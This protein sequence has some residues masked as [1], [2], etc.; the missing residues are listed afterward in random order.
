[1]DRYL[2]E[3]EDYL[4]REKSM[5]R[6]SMVA[7][8]RDLVEFYNFLVERGIEDLKETR[9]SDIVSY[10]LKLKNEGKSGATINRKAAALRAFGNFLTVRG[11]TTVSQASNIKTPKVDRKKVSYLTVRE[12]ENLLLLPDGSVKG[13]RDRAILELLYATGIR[14]TEIVEMNLAEVNLRIG[15]VSCSGEHGKARIIPLGRPAKAALE[16]YIYETRPQ[17]FERNGKNAKEES[18]LFVNFSGERLTRQGLWKLMKSY[19]AK[20]GFE[21]RLTPQT[22]RNSFAVH[23]LQ[24]GADLRSL[25]EL[26]GHE[27]ITTTQAYLEVTKAR[28]KE[29]YDN[30]H[31]RA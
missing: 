4:T 23:M 21:S 18:A 20:A 31:P 15:F 6:N 2:S 3:F 14:V 30:S 24:N 13:R 12:I 19:A 10:L 9:N 1:M 8:R 11:Y 17:I 16:D 22:I 27:D 26:L 7:Y 25:Q 28:I 29:V 5:A